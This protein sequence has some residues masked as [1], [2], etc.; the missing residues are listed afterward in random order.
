MKGI[1][2]QWSD[3]KGFGFIKPDNGSGKIFF[4]ISSV[5]TKERKPCA[6]DRVLFD[7]FFDS[8]QRLKA[9]CIVIEGVATEGAFPTSELDFIPIERIRKDV[10]DYILMAVCCSFLVA[11]G[12]GL[13]WFKNGWVSSGCGVAAVI[14]AVLFLQRKK[15]PKEK[16]FSCSGCMR[17]VDYDARTVKEWNKGAVKLYCEDCL[18]EWSQVKSS[19]N[20]S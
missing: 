4:H 9:E 6:G 13:F 14:I 18:A 7:T 3:E 10:F 20:I 15:K 17:I 8:E 19:S 2:D 16:S 5:V 11:A 1:V 12:F